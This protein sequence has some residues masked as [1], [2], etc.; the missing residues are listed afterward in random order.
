MDEVKLKNIVARKIT[1]G[2]HVSPEY[3][4]DGIF[5]ISGSEI[6]NGK[7][8][9]KKTTKKISYDLHN[10]FYKR[11]PTKVGDI[12]LVKNGSIGNCAFVDTS[13]LFSIW[14]PLAL[15]KIK[16]NFNSKF[17]YYNIIAEHTQ[18]Y[19]KENAADAAQPNI[20]ITTINNIIIPSI[21]LDQQTAIA[22]F[23]DIETS[24]IDKKVDLLSKKLEKLEEYKQS[25]IFETVTK[26]LDDSVQMKDSGIEWIGDIPTHWKVKRIKD[27]LDVSKGNPFDDKWDSVDG[28]Y[29][30][31]NGGI[32]PSG[33]S[34][35][36]NAKKNTIAVSEG[37]A[38]AGY[39]QFMTT[40][41]WAGSH[42]YKI[43]A[44]NPKIDNKYVYYILKGFQKALMSEKTGSAMPNLQKSKFINYVISLSNNIDEQNKII[45]FLDNKISQID[46]KIEIIK[47]QVELLK[48]YKQSL[49][50]EA[51][52]GKITTGEEKWK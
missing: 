19:L 50:Y 27:F 11:T 22:N 45:Y 44:Q 20:S 9:F 10:E 29:P 46:G 14:V 28:L 43:K 8:V 52:T 24:K 3:S 23:L 12:L 48:E 5:F 51:V 49:I 18:L 40:N 36:I 6:N 38:S 1:D 32:N 34:D 17:V 41:Y 31:I 47:K 13:E 16:K 25:I 33:W 7:I 30:Y 39:V 4:S 42:C 37:G 21:S 35:K 26:G 2:P 15:I